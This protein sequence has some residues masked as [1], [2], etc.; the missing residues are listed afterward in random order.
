LNAVLKESQKIV[1][2]YALWKLIILKSYI[3]V[4]F[5]KVNMFAME[6]AIYSMIQE[7]AVKSVH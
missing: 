4:I 6:Y 2:S 3:F 7:I 5:L 1:I